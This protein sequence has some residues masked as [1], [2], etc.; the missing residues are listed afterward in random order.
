MTGPGVRMF[1]VNVEVKKKKTSFCEKLRSGFAFLTLKVLDVTALVQGPSL[2]ERGT[3]LFE[4][5]TDFTTDGEGEEGHDD[6]RDRV[7]ERDVM[8]C[9]DL[10][11]TEE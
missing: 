8:R 3:A 2:D 9:K 7:R 4:P 5:N 11:P 1:E 6:G 10:L